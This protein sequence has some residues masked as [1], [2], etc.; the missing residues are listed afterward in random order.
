M[1]LLKIEN[2]SKSFNDKKIIDDISFNVQSGKIV[3]LLGKN[4]SGKTTLVSKTRLYVSR[5]KER[6]F[7]SLWF[8]SSS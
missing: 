7:L 4:G 1:S 8:S 2:V 5:A 3:G 6:T